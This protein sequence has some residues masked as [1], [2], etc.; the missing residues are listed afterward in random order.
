MAEIEKVTVRGKHTVYFIAEPHTAFQKP[1][2]RIFLSSVKK[3]LAKL[4]KKINAISAEGVILQKHYDEMESA[5]KSQGKVRSLTPNH[6][7]DE[8][9]TRNI[10]YL[11]LDGIGREPSLSDIIDIRKWGKRRKAK[12]LL[13]SWGSGNP[14]TG[15]W[16]NILMA[17]N[18]MEAVSTFEE[19]GEIANIAFVLHPEHVYGNFERDTMGV[20][21]YLKD[22]ELTEKR[23]NEIIQHTP[24]LHFF[25]EMGGL[26]MLGKKK[27]LSIPAYLLTKSGN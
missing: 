18:I 14:V 15:E 5:I 25:E 12:Q 1:A 22:P 16:R 27:V 21:D 2:E 19:R 23:Y 11:Q 7:T 3:T 8:A 17:K 26:L 13:E 10:P 4:P 24:E 9:I 6:I 20:I